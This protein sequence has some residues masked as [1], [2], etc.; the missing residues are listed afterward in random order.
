M[1]QNN[2]TYSLRAERDIQHIYRDTFKKWGE[3]QADKY[4]ASL[5]HSIDLIT[6]NPNLGRKC[7][8]IKSGYRRHESGHHIIFYRQRKNNILIIRILHEKMD[9]EKHF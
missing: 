5:K 2:H 1:R 8:Y 6:S 3:I 4:D 7:D 9:I